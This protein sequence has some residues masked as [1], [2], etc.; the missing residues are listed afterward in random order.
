MFITWR[1]VLHFYFVSW[2]VDIKTPNLHPWKKNRM[3][4][5]KKI[6]NLKFSVI[7][8]QWL[9][10]GIQEKWPTPELVEVLGQSNEVRGY[11]VLKIPA[12]ISKH[13]RD[14]WG[15]GLVHENMI[16]CMLSPSLFLLGC[17]QSLFFFQLLDFRLKL[18]FKSVP[19]HIISLFSSVGEWV[20]VLE[21]ATN[22]ARRLTS[23]L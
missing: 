13:G 22:Q 9:Y 3:L 10:R 17:V 12:D 20:R 1:Y 5:F 8:V 18:N 19:W 16:L 11:R 2:M 15:L 7:S 6:I 23:S 4:I 21:C 14:G